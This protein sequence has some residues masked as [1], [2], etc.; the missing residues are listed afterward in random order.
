MRIKQVKSCFPQKQTKSMPPSRMGLV[1][2]GWATCHRRLG[3]GC[4]APFLPPCGLWWEVGSIQA[5]DKERAFVW[6]RICLL[7]YLQVLHDIYNP[8]FLKSNTASSPQTYFLPGLPISGKG[9][10]ALQWSRLENLVSSSPPSPISCVTLCPRDD[11]AICLSHLYRHPPAHALHRGTS[12]SALSFTSPP[13]RHQ[14]QGLPKLKF[15]GACAQPHSLPDFLLPRGSGPG[16][17]PGFQR[18]HK[19]GLHRPFCLISHW[20]SLCTCLPISFSTTPLTATFLCLCSWH[21]VPY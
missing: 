8:T 21:Y 18:L 17:L 14:P 5:V 3:E 12:P 6:V 4:S 16:A 11:S 20:T 19:S 7:I 1:M 10:N 15:I 2:A 9:T 13:P